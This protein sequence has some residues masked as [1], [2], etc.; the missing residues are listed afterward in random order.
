[1]EHQICIN[2]ETDISK[3]EQLATLFAQFE[4]DG[5]H[6]GKSAGIRRF[7]Q[8]CGEI[9]QNEEHNIIMRAIEVINFLTIVQKIVKKTQRLTFIRLNIKIMG[10]YRNFDKLI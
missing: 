3:R 10:N 2:R 6:L 1:M 7:D 8:K 9:L 5:Q 4:I